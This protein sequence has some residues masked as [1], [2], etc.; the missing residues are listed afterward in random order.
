MH[1]RPVVLGAT[2]IAIALAF[3]ASAAGAGASAKLVADLQL[4]THEPGRPSGGKLHIVWPDAGRSGKPKPEKWGVFHL[5]A[6]TRVDE[7]A[8]PACTASDTELKARGGAACPAGSALGPGHV[9]FVTGI[10]NPVDPFATDNHWYH[11]P[12]QLIGLFHVRGTTNPTLAV[13]RVEIRGASF[14]ARPALPPGF[15]PGEKTVP[16]E[17]YQLIHRLVTSR[18]AFITT[19]PTCPRSRRW[20][21]RSAV[22]YDD[23]TVQR[24]T[25]VT[26]CTRRHG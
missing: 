24:T 4:T 21:A 12:K 18:G 1:A 2:S 10:G 5:P 9:D 7:A 19:P 25:T 17:S 15:P 14:I 3:G 22:G 13:N 8:I 6:G 26:R 11:G 16:K 23:G 20:V